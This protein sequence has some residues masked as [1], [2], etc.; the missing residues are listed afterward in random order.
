VP[1]RRTSSL[2]TVICTFLVRRLRA[3]HATK[4]QPGMASPESA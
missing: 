3:Q 4:P 2:I 1:F